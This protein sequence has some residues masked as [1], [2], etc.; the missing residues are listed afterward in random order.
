MLTEAEELYSELYERFHFLQ[1]S[2]M[3]QEEIKKVKVDDLRSVVQKNLDVNNTVMDLMSKWA[4][5]QN[6]GRA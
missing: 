3:L 6:F 1:G 2:V 4:D 5:I